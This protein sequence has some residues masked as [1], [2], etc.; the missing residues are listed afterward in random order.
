M[1]SCTSCCGTEEEKAAAKLA[2]KKAERKAARKAS[3]K[4]AKLEAEKAAMPEEEE[5]ACCISLCGCAGDPD[6]V[7]S[8]EGAVYDTRR[9]SYDDGGNLVY[10]LP[11]RDR[12]QE[13]REMMTL[14]TKAAKRL[15][16]R[17][18]WYI[19]DACWV[20][21]WL[22]FVHADENVAPA[23]GP[24][25]N[26]RLINETDV[27][28]VYKP[29]SHLVMEK[30]GKVG[31]YRKVT[32]E[33]WDL[34][35]KFYPESGPEVKAT[36]IDYLKEEGY[37][38]Q[39]PYTEKGN[40]PT[41][42]WVIGTVKHVKRRQ[43]V[44][45]KLVSLEPE[46]QFVAANMLP[47]EP[48]RAIENL[49]G[50]YDLAKIEEDNEDDDEDTGTAETKDDKEKDKGGDKG[51]EKEKKNETLVAQLK[52]ENALKSHSQPPPPPVKISEKKESSIKPP[53]EAPYTEAKETKEVKAPTSAPAPVP[54][55]VPAPAPVPPPKPV[56]PVVV[57][58]QKPIAE[59]HVMEDDDVKNIVKQRLA[60][61]K[62]DE[63]LKKEVESK[64]KSAGESGDG[65]GD[66]N[67]ED[68]T[69]TA[70]KKK[71]GPSRNDDFYNDMFEK[72]DSDENL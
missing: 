54:A 64:A 28:G 72:N 9:I 30:N 45:D 26:H 18:E 6:D 38:G 68:V 71:A 46:K 13:L 21:E 69:S 56:A 47:D 14:D 35:M 65:D 53:T 20:S 63:A 66:V 4:A 50:E 60:E 7:L 5:C 52:S 8:Q 24:C 27:D 48:E 36:F 15:K 41:D 10:G 11:P 58:N 19:M 33:T 42:T 23:P 16:P 1:G 3:K 12:N 34:F 31:D 59:E 51:G 62:R 22:Y 57:K 70:A 49:R 37:D 25:Y 55:P 67:K 43:S 29:K 61:K 32:K 40:Y 17:T 44:L 39:D 2:K